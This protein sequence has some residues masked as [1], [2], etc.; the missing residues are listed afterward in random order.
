MVE[1]RLRQ[2]P[3]EQAA[4]GMAVAASRPKSSKTG[5][6]AR[7]EPFGVQ[8]RFHY[9]DEKRGSPAARSRVAERDWRP[10]WRVERPRGTAD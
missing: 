4:D 5:S 2:S 3:G 8:R 6:I 7:I 9:L 1:S 10:P